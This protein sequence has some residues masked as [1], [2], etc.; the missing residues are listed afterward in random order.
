MIFLEVNVLTSDSLFLKKTIEESAFHNNRK[1]TINLYTRLWKF[2]YV[3][4]WLLARILY[5]IIK[6]PGY[7]INPAIIHS[8]VIHPC[9]IVGYLLAKRMNTELIISEHWTKVEKF[10]RRPVYKRIALKAYRE[11][12]AVICVSRFLSDLIISKTGC[13]NCV[14]I[15]NIINSGLFTFL[16]KPPV[17]KSFNIMC[18]ASWRLPKR[19]D[20]IFD[21]LCSYASETQIQ[22]NLRVAGNGPQVE[23]LKN[24]ETPDNLHIVWLGYKTKQDLAALLQSTHVFMHASDIETFSIVTAEA[25]STGTPVLISNNS[26]LPEL[27]DKNNGILAE[28]NPD[29]G[30]KES[31]KLSQTNM[32][33]KQFQKITEINIHRKSREQYNFSL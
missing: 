12:V 8:N 3:N 32:I 31:E 24:I 26:A 9:G 14:V 28:N 21:A 25:L 22:I 5:R 13:K 27:I 29:R 30:W 10:L 23:K 15:P 20:L 18:V 19:L 4:P 1:I 6:K 2:Y 33:T 7:K 11:S 16:P 17:D